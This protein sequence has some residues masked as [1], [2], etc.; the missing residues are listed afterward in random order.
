MPYIKKEQRERI[1]GAVQQLTESLKNL[2][3]PFV[4]EVD[5]GL[6]NYAVTKLLIGLGP[7][8]YADYNALVGVLECI[9]LEFYR[10]AVAPYEEKKIVAN[11]D[12]YNS[13]L[14]RAHAKEED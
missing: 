2:A 4:V 1:D 5:A 14:L 11:G 9:K 7:V 12:V 8:N 13:E 6:L 3:N 10:R